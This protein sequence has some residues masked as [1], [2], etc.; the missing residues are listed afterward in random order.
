MAARAAIRDAGRALGLPYALCD[1]V[2]KAIPMFTNFEQ[3]LEGSTD[4]SK[5]YKSDPQVKQLVDTARKLEGVCRHA[6]TH[7]AGVVIT[8]EPRT[9]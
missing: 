2:A 9:E 5:L 7:A 3:A 6:S 1:Q 8:D 4:L